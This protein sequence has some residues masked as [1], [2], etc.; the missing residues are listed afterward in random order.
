[1]LCTPVSI[2]ILLRFMFTKLVKW[3]DWT[4]SDSFRAANNPE[5]LLHRFDSG[6]PCIG[7]AQVPSRTS[8]WDSR[9]SLEEALQTSQSPVPGSVLKTDKY[10]LDEINSELDKCPSGLY[11]RHPFLTRPFR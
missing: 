1:M 9:E 10:I 5:L 7:K 3:F 2:Y 8:H 11:F 6:F 4:P